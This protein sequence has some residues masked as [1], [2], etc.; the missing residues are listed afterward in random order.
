MS[1]EPWD[2]YRQLFPH[3]ILKRHLFQLVSD[4]G[5]IDETQLNRLV[6]KL[7]ELRRPHVVETAASPALAESLS[8]TFLIVPF[9]I[10]TG[11]IICFLGSRISM[12]GQAAFEST[13]SQLSTLFSLVASVVTAQRVLN[14]G[15]AF[16]AVGL[17]LSLARH[18]LEFVAHPR[19]YSIAHASRGT[20]AKVTDYVSAYIKK[21]RGHEIVGIVYLWSTRDST[22]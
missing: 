13:S 19:P 5:V 9:V 2:H 12:T 22:R 3:A 18:L 15:F 8:I 4:E 17:G 20:E 1:S 14:A 21:E 11:L 7:R 6:D 10:G 16:C